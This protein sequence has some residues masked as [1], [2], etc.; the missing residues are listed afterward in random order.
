MMDFIYVALT[1]LVLSVLAAWFPAQKAAKFPLLFTL[2][3]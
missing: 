3:R 2:K 1:V